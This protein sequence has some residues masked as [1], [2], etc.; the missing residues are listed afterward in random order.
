[1]CLG[2]NYIPMTEGEQN[3]LLHCETNLKN[4]EVEKGKNKQAS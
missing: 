2:F 1:M 4:K 3:T